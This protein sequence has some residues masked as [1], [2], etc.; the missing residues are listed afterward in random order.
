MSGRYDAG[1]YR[2]WILIGLFIAVVVCV[3]TMATLV[4]SINGQNNKT[5]VLTT[6]MESGGMPIPTDGGVTCVQS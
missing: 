4:G 6:C 1:Q 2:T 5:K 3:V